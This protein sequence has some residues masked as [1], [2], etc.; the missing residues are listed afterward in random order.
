MADFLYGVGAP[1]WS[2]AARQAWFDTW[3]CVCLAVSFLVRSGSSPEKEGSPPFPPLL[4]PT[5]GWPP[6]DRLVSAPQL[7]TPGWPLEERRETPPRQFLFFSFLFFFF[8]WWGDGERL[9]VGGFLGGEG[10][11]VLGVVGGWVRGC[12]R[13]G[14]GFLSLM[15]SSLFFLP[16]ALTFL[17]KTE[18]ILAVTVFVYLPFYGVLS[19]FFVYFF[20]NSLSI[21][22]VWGSYLV[23]VAVVFPSV[24]CLFVVFLVFFGSYLLMYI[25]T[26]GTP[27]L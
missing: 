21:S 25:F 11:G 1:P 12:S 24:F 27:P 14:D 19:I 3:C 6:R 10:L 20:F 16:S 9:G 5:L 7:P 8:F 15:C 23:A 26:M 2:R 13:V 17:W 4:A 18:G 22:P